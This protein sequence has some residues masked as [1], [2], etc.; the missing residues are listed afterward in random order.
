MDR[1]GYIV[2]TGLSSKTYLIQYIYSE[3]ISP[4]FSS[5]LILTGL[6][7][8]THVLATQ[9]WRARGLWHPHRCYAENLYIEIPLIVIY[10]I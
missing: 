3:A 5:H 10:T 2:I 7:I 9:P 8:H 1:K 6:G 4:T